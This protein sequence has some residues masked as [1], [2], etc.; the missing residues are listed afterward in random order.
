MRLRLVAGLV[1]ATAPLLAMPATARADV[2]ITPVCTT[3][4][5]A[6][7]CSAGWYTTNVTISFSLSGSGFTISSGCGSSS[8]TADTADFPASCVVDIGGGNL[9]GKTVHVKRD[10]TPPN[11]TGITADR[12]PDANGWYNHAVT[13]SVA[14]ND[15]M[16]GLA[17]C[18]VV[19]YNGPDSG[20]AAVTGSC[21][22]NAGNVSAPQTLGLKYDATPPSVVPSPSRGSDAN[23]WY[24]HPVDVAFKGTDAVSGIDSCTSGGY[25]GPDSGGTSVSGSC[26]D[27]AGNV[28]TGSFALQYDATPPSVT[29]AAADRPPDVGDWYNHR[30]VVTFSG[31]DATSGVASCDSDPYEQPDDANVT[32]TGRCRDNAGNVSDAGTFAL[33]FDSTPPKLSDLSASSLDRSVALKWKASADVAHLTI[34]RV[35]GSGDPT[36]VYDGGAVAAFTDKALRNGVRY[37]YTVTAQDAAG[38]DAVEKVAAEP[39]PPLIAP[40]S[41]ARVR[42]AVTLRWRAVPKATYYNIQL[43]LRGTKVLTRW[44]TG[45]TFKVPSSWTYGGRT[46][47]LRPGRYV[48]HVWPGFGARPK[49]RF[50]A[51]I[52]TSSFVVTR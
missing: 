26:R 18:S 35:A 9:V 44:P 52:G 6:G 10:A 11:A 3:P 47:R 15:A 21:R 42:G 32:L 39:T 34:A 37:V 12:S 25:S 2:V 7:S 41:E 43:W 36:T 4:A 40:R 28:G 50:G 45:T 46:L 48:W 27:V 5:G 13:I 33:K 1:L 14:G 16:S 51:L 8:V 17:A 38:N 19:T 31:A 20:T 22:D 23:G 24:N 30:V 49:H 29:G